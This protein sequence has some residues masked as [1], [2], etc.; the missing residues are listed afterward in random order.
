MA[1]KLR[2]AAGRAR[3]RLRARTVQRCFG[4]SGGVGFRQ[5]LLRGLEKVSGEWT[6]VCLAY[7]LR[8]LHR[9]G[10]G[11][12]RGDGGLKVRPARSK[13]TTSAPTGAVVHP[14][15]GDAF[16]ASLAETH[17]PRHPDCN[18]SCRTTPLSE[19]RQTPGAAARVRPIQNHSNRESLSD[20][21]RCPRPWASGATAA[22]ATNAN[23]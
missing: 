14:E 13:P 18:Q 22:F 20:Q 17:H 9:R 10:G 4:G 15:S 11:A 8:R 3:Y 23:R 19:V 5:F 2:T 6:L 1:E 12:E 7:N 21:A 16:L